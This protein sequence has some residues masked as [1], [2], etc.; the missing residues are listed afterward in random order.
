MASNL[1]PGVSSSM[2]DP[3]WSAFTALIESLSNEELLLIDFEN[4]DVQT[5]VDKLYAAGKIEG[6]EGDRVELGLYLGQASLT[7]QLQ[8][9]RQEGS[10]VALR[11]E[12]LEAALK[13]YGV[14][15]A[16]C[17]KAE[18]PNGDK[19]TCGFDSSLEAP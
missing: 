9:L 13:Y 3:P 14:H 15:H 18:L 10:P 11:V 12:V 5:L 4:G 19:C 8:W 2:I 6:E 7:N 17:L 1:P 16:G